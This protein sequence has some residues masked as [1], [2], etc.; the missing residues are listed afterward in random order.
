MRSRDFPG[1]VVDSDQRLGTLI[2]FRNKL[3]L[4][5][6]AGRGRKL[7][8]PEADVSYHKTTDHVNVVVLASEIDRFQVL[9]IDDTLGRLVENGSLEGMIFLAYLH[10]LTSFVL[11]DKFTTRSGTEQALEILTSAAAKS[12]S[13][14][15]Q[16]AADLLGQIA[17][18]S[19]TRK[20]YP[21]HK[22]AM[23]QVAWDDQLSFFSQQ[24]QLCTAV[25]EIF[26]HAR[27]MQLFHPNATVE[28]A[29]VDS[30][31]EDW[32]QRYLSRTAMFR[33]SGFGAEDQLLRQ[34]RVYK[35]RD[36]QE[37]SERSHRAA[38][39]AALSYGNAGSL[40]QP[41]HKTTYLWPMLATTD[42]VRGRR[43]RLNP[44]DIR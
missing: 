35:A 13:C 2:G 14:L 41:V 21:P 8:I 4:K 19:P 37:E 15:T 26:S 33:I 44:E 3:L 28:L 22:H 17:R 16:R 11:P 43:S 29:Q 1:Y 31:K 18:L 23:Q 12:F 20:Y 5:Q 25:S 9:E 40:V 32:Y 30:V 24:D 36:C 27:R 39:I 10:A 34:D 38:A 42:H 6:I 7:L